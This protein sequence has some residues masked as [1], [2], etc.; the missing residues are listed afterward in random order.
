[1][2]KMLDHLANTEMPDCADAKLGKSLYYIQA[3]RRLITTPVLEYV[4]KK[5]CVLGKENYANKQHC[6]NIY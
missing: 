5:L 2:N 4:Q 1:M 3:E 6:V